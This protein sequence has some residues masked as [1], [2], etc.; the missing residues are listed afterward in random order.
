MR[1][2]SMNDKRAGFTV[3]V[4]DNRIYALGNKKNYLYI[5]KS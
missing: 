5:K 3:S 4:V 2:A 1:I